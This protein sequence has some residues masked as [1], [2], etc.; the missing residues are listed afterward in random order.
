MASF[1][2]AFSCIGIMAHWVLPFGFDSIYQSSR[3]KVLLRKSLFLAQILSAPHQWAFRV[4]GV[5]LNFNLNRS[6][7]V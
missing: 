2:T 6:I 3:F 5:D 7:L 4:F 1:I